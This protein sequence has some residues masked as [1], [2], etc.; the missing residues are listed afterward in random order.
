[1]LGYL[2][3]NIFGGIATRSIDPKHIVIAM[4]AVWSAA[5]FATGFIRSLA[6]LVACRLVIG[7][8]EGVYWPQQSRFVKG[9]FSPLELTK[10][11]AVIQFYGMYFALSFGYLFLTPFFDRYGWRN[12]FFL[13]GA[14][15]FALVP[16][17]YYLLKKE[18]ESPYIQ[19]EP[20]RPRITLKAL[21]G[22]PFL[23][24]PFIYTTQGMLFWG[25]TL[26]IPM[27][28]KSLGYTGI[29]QGI[30]S[31]TPYFAALIL[32]VPLSIASDRTGKRAL[33]AASG[34]LIPGV[35]LLGLPFVGSA[36][37][38]MVL[39]TLSFSYYASALTPNIWAI[40]QSSVEPA[41]VG[42][43]AGIV[44]GIGAGCGGT[45]A[46]WVVGL[47]LK[48]TGSY[49]PGFTVIGAAAVLGGTSIFLFDKYKRIDTA[50]V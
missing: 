49:I 28:V 16:L 10:A 11:N 12:L 46:G 43:A 1:V 7:L 9:W 19:Q 23:F 35:L 47:L 33:I 15:G 48:A 2:V 18:S 20:T 38:K 32:A 27:V 22:P 21:G 8:A 5:T 4:L 31:S 6:V 29:N 50:K 45:I 42:P 39:I 25:I 34:L 26:W 30:A 14:A 41:M 13:T 36:L 37:G 24:L 17:F 40:I 3:S 44:N